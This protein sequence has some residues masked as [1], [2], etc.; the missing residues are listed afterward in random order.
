MATTPPAR[1]ASAPAQAVRHLGR[2][3]LLRLL[4]KSARSM[5]WLVADP[6]S[7]QEMLLVL[8][9]AQPADAAALQRWMETARRASRIDHPGLEPAVEVG[10][11]DR[12]PYI[13]YDRGTGSTLAERLGSKGLPGAELVPQVLQVLQGLAFA[14]EAGF[15]HHDVQA[16]MLVVHDSGNCTLMGLGVVSP[17]AG[18]GSDLQSQRRAAERDVLALGLVLHHALAGTAPLEQAD[19]GLVIERMPPA[20]REIVRLPWTGAHPIPE[21]LR[22]IINRATD[23]QERQRYRNA[24]TLERALSGWLRTD[25]EASGGPIML[26]L[27][28]MR[29]AGLLP[30][31]PGGGSRAG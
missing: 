29:A 8:P 18:E 4:G 28:R 14:H 22:A 9:R 11:H 15:A 5:L 31:M 23:R 30:A 13:A 2:F 17:P 12:W 3:Q 26:L 7:G 1:P 21:P 10:E 20:G 27:D 16:G 25:G 6:R 19:T 24:R